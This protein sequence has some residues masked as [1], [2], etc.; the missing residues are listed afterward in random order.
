LVTGGELL[1]LDHL[2]QVSLL[3]TISLPSSSQIRCKCI[4]HVTLRYVTFNIIMVFMLNYYILR[5]TFN[6]SAVQQEY[7]IT[8]DISKIL[9]AS[10]LNV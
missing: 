3:T 4:L 2:V 5:D 1:R 8:A 7:K 10:M 9:Q 6:N